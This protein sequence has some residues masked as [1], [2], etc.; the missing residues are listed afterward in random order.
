MPPISFPKQ[1]WYYA[2]VFLGCCS[3]GFFITG[4]F[5]WFPGRELPLSWFDTAIPYLH[6]TILIYASY[7]PLMILPM[8]V[9][10]H[11][12]QLRRMFFGYLLIVAISVSIFFLYPTAIPAEYNGL[13]STNPL[14]RLVRTIIVNADTRWNAFPSLHVSISLAGAF[15]YLWHNQYSKGWFFLI[16]GFLI[17]LSTITARRHYFADVVGGTVICFL[18]VA[19]VNIWCDHV[20]RRPTP[21]SIKP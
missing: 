13:A 10:Q 9:C 12:E 11:Q 2:L 1:N 14:I 7:Y 18:S 19:V 16:W 6:W 21:I 8:L 3:A 4:R 20:A 15:A 17:A 5:Q